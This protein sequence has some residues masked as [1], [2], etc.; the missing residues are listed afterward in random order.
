MPFSICIFTSRDE[1]SCGNRSFD[2]ARGRF[3]SILVEKLENF[4]INRIYWIEVTAVGA[5]V[6]GFL[7]KV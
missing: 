7:E 3:P 6:V 5:L 1:L 4:R 2:V